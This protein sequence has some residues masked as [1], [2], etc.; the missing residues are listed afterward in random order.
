MECGQFEVKRF[1]FLAWTSWAGLAGARPGQARASGATPGQA[2]AL[3]LARLGAWARPCLVQA[4]QAGSGGSPGDGGMV[5][6]PRPHRRSPLPPAIR[7]DAWLS[8]SWPG[9]GWAGWAGAGRGWR[10]SCL[11]LGGPLLGVALVCDH[12]IYA[13]RDTPTGPDLN[14]PVRPSACWPPAN[15]VE[16]PLWQLRLPSHPRVHTM[17]LQ[18]CLTQMM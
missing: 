16:C 9:C 5:T 10:P 6:I 12:T 13:G 8:W 14:R 3:D 11:P 7:D 2:E 4:L 17:T 1:G 15:Y 18:L